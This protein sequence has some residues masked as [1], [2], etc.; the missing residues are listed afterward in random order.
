MTKSL[1]APLETRSMSFPSQEILPA[2]IE[3]ALA[4]T[5]ASH[6]DALRIFFE[7]D[8]RLGRI[9][10]GTNEAML[11][12]MRLAWWRETLAKPANERPSGDAVL[13]AIGEQFA[14]RETALFSLVDGWEHLL[15]DPPLG[16]EDALA[17]AKGRADA[18]VS[19]LVKNEQREGQIEAQRWALADLACNVSHEE[20][21][22]ML[23][24]LG[25]AL[26]EA[27]S[28]L[29]AAMKG[30]SILAALSLRS[31]KNGGRPLMEG[32]GASLTALRAAFFG[33]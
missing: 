7:L 2:E 28:R 6:R 21:R 10:A 26:G 33:R 17:F 4:Y 29:P 14:G 16:K 31:L 19:V 23:T 8:A 18:L 1:L 22:A 24:A 25:L 30:L 5:P 3:L 9:V 32:R 12:Q 27:H 15:A 13:D 11:G 20:E